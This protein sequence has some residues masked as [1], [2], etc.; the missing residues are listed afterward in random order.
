M[1]TLRILAAIVLC[2]PQLASA[3]NEVFDVHVHLWHG[4][5]SVREYTEQQASTGQDATRFGAILMAERG[6][7]AQTRANNDELIA[8]AKRYPK[9]VPIASVHPL[10]GDAA[11]AELK[12]IA[13]SGVKAIK[14]HPHSQ[15]F[16]IT[17]PRVRA[18]CELAGE[19]GVTVLFDNFNVVP[20]DSQDLFNLA[21]QLPKTQF[22][23]AHMGGLNFR[24]WNSLV[25]ARTAKDFFFDNIHF[26]ISATAVLVADSP[27]EAE[28]VW[29]IR[30]VGI[31]NVMLGSD[32][33]QLS[34]KQA[35]DALE[36]LD[37]TA[38]EKRKIRWE[39]ADRLFGGRR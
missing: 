15:R 11:R 18:L 4:E 38:E 9:L 19:L 27:L 1:K 7:P 36:K 5:R 14:L 22:I 32:Y 28:F 6:K 31:D 34:L 20:G 3:Q 10:D 35:L 25:L 24:F 39:N 17:D 16:A 12:R 29:T 30:N 13:A 2:L 33:P 8:L 21:V 26:D 23:F 37:L